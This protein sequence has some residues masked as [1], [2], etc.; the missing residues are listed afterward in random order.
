MACYVSHLPSPNGLNPKVHSI[1]KAESRYRRFV[2]IADEY[3]ARLQQEK[4]DLWSGF[5]ETAGDEKVPD[6][7]HDD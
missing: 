4:P 3:R 7:Q 2:V 1:E 6:A 5:F